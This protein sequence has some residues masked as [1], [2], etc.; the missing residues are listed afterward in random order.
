MNSVGLMT[1]GSLLIPKVDFIEI[2][3]QVFRKKLLMI[4]LA[5]NAL[6]I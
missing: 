3:R 2:F 4:Y 1:Q 5:I 6:Y